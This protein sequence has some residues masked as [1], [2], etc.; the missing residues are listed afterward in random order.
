MG[1]LKEAADSGD[2]LQTLI[3]LRQLLADRLETSRSDRDIASMSRRLMQ[4][5]VEIEKLEKDKAA[6]K[7]DQLAKIR[8]QISYFADT[9]M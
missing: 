3:E 8:R 1:K 4:V 9:K 7:N 6:H 5:C 2:R